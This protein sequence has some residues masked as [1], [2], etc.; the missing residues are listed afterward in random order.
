MK[1]LRQFRFQTLVLKFLEGR[2]Q[3]FNYPVL[4]QVKEPLSGL[5]DEH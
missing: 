2:S 5:G 1:N 3:L 4:K